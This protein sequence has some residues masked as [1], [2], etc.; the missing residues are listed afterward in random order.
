MK[1]NLVSRFLC[2]LPVFII[3]FLNP[4]NVKA[5]SFGF[6][7]DTEADGAAGIELFSVAGVTVKINGE[8]NAELKVFFNDFKSGETF[9]NTRLGD[10]FTGNLG[11]SASAAA[12]DAIINLNLV[13]VFDGSSSPI[14]I[15]EAY[16]RV[17]FGPMNIEG[18]L[19]KLTWGKADS[20]GPMDVINPLDYS[21]LSALSDPQS[22]KISRPLLHF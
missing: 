9:K 18:G 2:L 4:L 13:P 7:D 21:D 1:G 12:A 16:V 3:L 22:I 20:F 10:I 8:A 17:F 5:Q 15:D 14:T 11:F 19:R 6:G